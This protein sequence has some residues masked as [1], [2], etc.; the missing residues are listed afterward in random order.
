[1]TFLLEKLLLVTT[2]SAPHSNFRIFLEDGGPLNE[3]T[4]QM[5]L[6]DRLLLDSPE[7][8]L[9]GDG[10]DKAMKVKASRSEVVT[11]L[12][13]IY[14]RCYSERD[15]PLS[16]VIQKVSIEHHEEYILCLFIILFCFLIDVARELF[17]QNTYL[18]NKKHMLTCQGGDWLL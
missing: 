2:R 3:E 17:R 14:G 8:H 12:S 6:F 1:M 15:S 7:S 5:V 10:C 11:Y 13:E 16:H 18:Q 4:L 9:I